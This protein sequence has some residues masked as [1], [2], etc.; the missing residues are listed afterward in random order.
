MSDVALGNR[1]NVTN[2]NLAFYVQ[3]INETT[4]NFTYQTGQLSYRQPPEKKETT[5]HS[6][7]K[8]W[9]FNFRILSSLYDSNHGFVAFCYR[10]NL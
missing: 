1:R 5:A 8:S 7:E 6:G 3:I 2:E 4:M 9:Q 10:R